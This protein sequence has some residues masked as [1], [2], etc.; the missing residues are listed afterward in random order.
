MFGEH[1]W[2]SL[3]RALGRLSW[4]CLHHRMECPGNQTCL[5][6]CP[7]LAW[8]SAWPVGGLW[9]RLW[10][11]GP[12]GCPGSVRGWQAL[13]LSSPSA[14]KVSWFT[15]PH[16]QCEFTVCREQAPG[17]LVWWHTTEPTHRLGLCFSQV[18]RSWFWAE[19]SAPVGR[20]GCL[21]MYRPVHVS[22]LKSKTGWVHIVAQRSDQGSQSRPSRGRG[23]AGGWLSR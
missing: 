19:L 8:P 3:P 22:F 14:E 5:S 21:A 17:S 4:R 18:E 7:V 12:V 10:E 16:L 13:S 2:A 1:R 6:S 20:L 15:A 11:H 23:A 9:A